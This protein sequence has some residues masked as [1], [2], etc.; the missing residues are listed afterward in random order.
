MFLDTFVRQFMYKGRGLF[1]GKTCTYVYI[2]N[3]IKSEIDKFGRRIKS[4]TIDCQSIGG[5][6]IFNNFYATYNICKYDLHDKDL[7][8]YRMFL[9]Y[10]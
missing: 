6:N 8:L 7:F 2:W 3:K 5:L 4:H 10:V 1:L 9:H